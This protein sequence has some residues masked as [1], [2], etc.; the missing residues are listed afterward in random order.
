MEGS[1][2]QS[3]K[4]G[5]GLQLT[6]TTF[7]SVLVMHI[8]S[9]FM[10][11]NQLGLSTSTV[12]NITGDTETWEQFLTDSWNEYFTL[13]YSYMLLKVRMLFDPPTSGILTD[14]TERVIREY[15]YRLSTQV[16]TNLT[17]YPPA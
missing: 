14:S 17:F 1:I 2:L 9:V 3:I 13:V 4:R 12:F 11:L 16:E 8:N 5:L 15:E 10:I 7:D 6:N